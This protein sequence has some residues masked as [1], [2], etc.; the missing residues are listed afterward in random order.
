MNFTKQMILALTFIFLF[1]KPVLSQD[2]PWESLY[3][4]A[5][6]LINEGKFEDGTR[7]A[8]KALKAAELTTDQKDL[9]VALS[10]KVLIHYFML[11]GKFK[12]AEP[13]VQQAAG[14]AQDD[15]NMLNN[16][17]MIY[18]EAG[19]FPEA[20][21]ISE[22]AVHLAEMKFGSNSSEMTESLS[23]LAGVYRTEGKYEQALPLYERVLDLW[24]T[25]LGEKHPNTVFTMGNLGSVYGALGEYDRADL[26]L[27]KVLS[28]H[29]STLPKDHPTFALSLR[30]LGKLRIREGRFVA[31]ESYL[32]EALKIQEKSLGKSHPEVGATLARFGLLYR[33]QKDFKQAES[34][35][36]RSHKIFEKVYGADNPYTQDIEKELQVLGEQRENN[37]K[38]RGK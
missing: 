10:L 7:I 11:Q 6:Q 29:K 14:I 27:E 34:F 16:L 19:N 20:E 13:F 32:K 28:I 38:N 12:E 1:C 4:Q 35:Y 36:K 3:A 5:G 2:I 24:K 33:L 31:A 23:T 26:L 25:E 18:T 15:A 30:E 8:R 9:K 17:A 22:R 37:A 21:K